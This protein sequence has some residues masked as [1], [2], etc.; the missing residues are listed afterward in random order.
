MSTTET[1][2]YEGVSRYLKERNL[3]VQI[4]RRKLTEG[5]CVAGIR[6]WPPECLPTIYA[7]AR[8]DRNH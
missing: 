3:V 5:S 6:R 4:V 7:P 8:V 2:I 1:T